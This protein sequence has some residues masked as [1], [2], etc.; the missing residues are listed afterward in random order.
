MK[1]SLAPGP[2]FLTGIQHQCQIGLLLRFCQRKHTQRCPLMASYFY[3]AGPPVGGLGRFLRIHLALPFSPR[4]P[5]AESFFPMCPPLLSS[6]PV[7]TSPGKTVKGGLPF[8]TEKGDGEKGGRFSFSG[9][10]PLLRS[11]GQA[12]ET[13]LDF[14]RRSQEEKRGEA[15]WMYLRKKVFLTN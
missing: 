12:W 6:P 2:R 8:S 3:D 10:L 5:S 13:M 14:S 1:Q 9:T 4:F 15:C 7:F 11:R